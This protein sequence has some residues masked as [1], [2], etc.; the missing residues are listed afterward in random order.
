MTKLVNSKLV[1]MNNTHNMPSRQLLNRFCPTHWL[2][3]I[4][5]GLA[6]A[7]VAFR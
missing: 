1:M 4:K 7:A 3:R 2:M 5:S 6:T